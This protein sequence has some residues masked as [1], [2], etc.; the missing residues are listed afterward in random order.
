MYG[1]VD[2]W[3]G[4]V[5]LFHTEGPCL[6][7]LFP[8]VKE[9]LFQNCEISGILGSSSGLVALFQLQLVLKWILFKER[10]SLFYVVNTR[11]F[12]IQPIDFPPHSFCQRCQKEERKENKADHFYISLETMKEWQREKPQVKLLDVREE[13]LFHESSL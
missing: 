4:Q 5:A 6:E 13:E 12:D 8:E 2:R 7:C 9:G 3:M 1:S 10:E 11:S